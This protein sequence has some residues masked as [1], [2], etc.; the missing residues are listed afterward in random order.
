MKTICTILLVC[1]TFLSNAQTLEYNRTIDTLL[2]ITIPGGTVFNIT[3]RQIIGNYISAPSNKVWK[4]QS[5]IV[6]P[7]PAFDINGN[8]ILLYQSANNYGDFNSISARISLMLKNN[9]FENELF[10][11]P[12]PGQGTANQGSNKISSPIWL[13]NSELG[14]AFTHTLNQAVSQN[15]PYLNPNWGSYTGYVHLSILEFNTN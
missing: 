8:S 13:N 15:N 12:I 4:V 6:M 7:V 10:S 11:D 5:I 2:A 3:N 9:S 1:L 14:I